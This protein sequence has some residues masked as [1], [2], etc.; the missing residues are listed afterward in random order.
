MGGLLLAVGLAVGLVP[1]L[2]VG[3]AAL[4]TVELRVLVAEMAEEIVSGR[5]EK[6]EGD[7]M[8]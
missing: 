2:I 8:A 7:E 4:L 3:L 6:S 1:A 5:G